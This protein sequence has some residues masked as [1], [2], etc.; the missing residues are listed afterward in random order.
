M[1][2]IFF[3]TVA[4][5]S[6]ALAFA[7]DTALNL[8]RPFAETTKHVPVTIESTQKGSCRQ[9]SE[10]IKREDAWHCVSESGVTYD[11]CFSK[12]FGPNNRVVC[13]QSPWIGNSVQLELN[14]PL[15]ERNM[16]MLDMSRTMPWAIELKNGERCLS[17]APYQTRDGL[18]VNYRC[19][20]G[21]E[22]VGEAHRCS[23]VWTILMHDASGISMAELS[24]AWF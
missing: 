21:A 2:R 20:N 3:F 1:S 8:Y 18:P 17:V 15:D 16:V 9:Q 10:R 22:L 7:A 11:P 12:R 4:I 13:P 6:P 14:Q 19:M 24:S 5:M 23:P